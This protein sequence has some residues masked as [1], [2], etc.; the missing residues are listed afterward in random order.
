[1]TK[2]IA[3]T[4]DGRTFQPKGPV[5]LPARVEGRVL[6]EESLAAKRVALKARFPSIV[7]VIDGETAAEWMRIVDESRQESMMAEKSID[8]WA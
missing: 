7:G 2:T 6:V 8:G 5:D 3:V 4:F 1:M